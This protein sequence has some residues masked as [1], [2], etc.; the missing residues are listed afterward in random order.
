M[1]SN[2]KLRLQGVRLQMLHPIRGVKHFE[3]KSI[4]RSPKA[5]LKPFEAFEAIEGGDCRGNI[6]LTL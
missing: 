4:T 3:A 5:S 6:T 2:F 1:T